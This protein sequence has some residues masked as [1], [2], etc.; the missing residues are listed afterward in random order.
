MTTSPPHLVRPR[1]VWGGV[2]ITLLGL[3]AVAVGVVVLSWTWSL[4]GVVAA[5]A[6]AA[7]AWRGGVLHDARG[8][9]HGAA[10]EVVRGS[11][12]PGVAPGATLSGPAISRDAVATEQRR[13]RLERAAATGPRP[14]DAAPAGGVL[15]LLTLF[16]TVAQWELY[17]LE[18]PGQD[19]AVR[20]LGAAIVLGAAGL[21]MLTARSRPHVLAAGLSVAAGCALLANGVLASHDVVSTAAAEGVCGVLAAGCGVAVLAVSRRSRRQDR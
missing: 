11:V 21:R 14:P 7:V 15:V 5:A 18:R 10:H 13:R 1:W 6:G 2:L 16:L 20:A 19:N 4:G 8:G 17:P 12:H 3:A 9:L